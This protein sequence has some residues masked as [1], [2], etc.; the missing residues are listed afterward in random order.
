MPVLTILAPQVAA[1]AGQAKALMSRK[2]VV[3]RRFFDRPDVHGR[4]FPVDDGIKRPAP[5]FTV[6]AESP[7]AVFDDAL[8]WAQPALDGPAVGFSVKHRFLARGGV[9]RRRAGFRRKSTRP[10]EERGHGFQKTPS[11]RHC[12][13]TPL[14]S[15]ILCHFRI[16]VKTRMSSQLPVLTRARKKQAALSPSTGSRRIPPA[17]PPRNPPRRSAP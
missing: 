14:F 8:T 9:F 13:L 7:P 17:R 6:P 15:K 16:F 12:R 5:V 4:R 1:R 2:E 11:A 3:E 10:R